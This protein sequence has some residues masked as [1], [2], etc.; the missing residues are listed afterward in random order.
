MLKL[1]QIIEISILISP[2]SNQLDDDEHDQL[3]KIIKSPQE[4]N[5]MH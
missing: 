1:D 4:T 5:R 2:S 3:R